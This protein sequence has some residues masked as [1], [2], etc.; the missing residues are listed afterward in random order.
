[1][2]S[3]DRQYKNTGAF[4]YQIVSTPLTPLDCACLG[5][6]HFNHRV[7]QDGVGFVTRNGYMDIIERA[8]KLFM[9][10]VER[11]AGADQL[12]IQRLAAMRVQIGF[13]AALKKMEAAILTRDWEAMDVLIDEGAPVNAST[14]G[15]HTLLT[16][17]AY[18]GLS[19]V[20][21]EQRQVLAVELLMD[22][23][24]GQVAPAPDGEAKNKH[25]PLTIA[26]YNGRHNVIEALMF[27]GANV[28]HVT[29]EGRTALMF[30]CMNAKT[31]IVRLLLGLG[32]L[33]DFKDFEG[34]DAMWYA[35]ENGMP[36]A[37]Q[38]IGDAR[39]RMKSSVVV[40]T[41]FDPVLSCPWG[42]GNNFHESV[43]SIHIE[44][45]RRVV[46]SCPLSCGVVGM[47]RDELQDHMQL[48]CR[49]KRVRCPQACI[50]VVCQDDV[51]EHLKSVCGRTEMVC[52]LGCGK[53]LA[54]EE[55]PSHAYKY[56]PFR[57]Q[58]CALCGEEMDYRVV[59]RHTN[60]L[61]PLRQVPCG[62]ECGAMMTSVERLAHEAGDCP[63]KPAT[64]KCGMEFPTSQLAE[65]LVHA[66]ADRVVVCTRGCGRS[67]VARDL[68]EH[69][70]DSCALRFVLCPDKCGA[71]VCVRDLKYHKNEVCKFRWV[72]CRWDRCIHKMRECERWVHEEQQCKRRQVPCGQGCGIYTGLKLIEAHKRDECT[73]R[74]VP[75]RRQECVVQV[76]LN[77]MDE[78]L[79]MTCRYRFVYCPL[80]CK[81]VI[82]FATSGR[83][84]SK[85]CPERLVA[86]VWG[87]GDQ[88]K[89]MD[90]A[91]HEVS[92][93]LHR[94][95]A[96]AAPVAAPKPKRRV[97]PA[98]E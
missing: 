98:A 48:S 7:W 75:C 66:C 70:D 90:I 39:L 56:C 24:P 60:R 52:E 51:T 34:R 86:C 33:C 62:R 50:M 95:V 3:V 73:H 4:P 18:T 87:C 72:N 67:V 10:Y 42:C 29:T 79:Q 27:R 96:V 85:E 41:T 20:N 63:L 58:R 11:Q 35:V 49:R 38:M 13:A 6:Y 64:C 97:L 88:V 19:A 54:R 77:E 17:A 12:R 46:V 94:V 26:A 89:A 28:N 71:R 83:H 57:R 32:A 47:F 55:W 15:G 9:Y 76:R 74:F 69:L 36:E 61:C 91:L 22:R 92:Q 37:V 44:T 84:Q 23:P 65:H 78:H 16:I 82:P 31:D 53:T 1:M 25:T 14:E 80:G 81:Q 30:A 5:Y 59:H 45:C 8:Q 2:T 40:R 93:C 43:L 68:Q 21:R